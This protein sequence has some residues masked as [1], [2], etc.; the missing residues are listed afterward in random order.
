M[1]T[2]YQPEFM[3]TPL[4]H[5]QSRHTPRMSWEEKEAL[6]NEIQNLLEK[7]AIKPVSQTMGFYSNLLV[8][9][10]KDRGWRPVIN[11]KS[12]NMC[13]KKFHFKM[14]GIQNLKDT[15]SPNDHMAKLDFKILLGGQCTRIFVPPVWTIPSTSSLHQAAKT[16]CHLQRKQGIRMLVYLDDMLQMAHSEEELS[17]QP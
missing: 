10:K 9:P 14:E 15:L 16:G 1:V 2:G 12:L 5:R 3:S 7:R 17:K 11:L 13:L 4:L 8:V 6:T